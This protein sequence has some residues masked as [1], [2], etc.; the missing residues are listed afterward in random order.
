MDEIAN[1]CGRKLENK[2]LLPYEKFA[3]ISIGRK[4]KFA[5]IIFI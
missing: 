2:I 1:P 3:I 5:I 4:V